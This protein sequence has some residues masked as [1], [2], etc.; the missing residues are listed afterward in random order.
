MVISVKCL[1]LWDPCLLQA[2]CV[3]FAWSNVIIEDYKN[4]EI[5]ESKS[6]GVQL[7]KECLLISP[8]SQRNRIR[9]TTQPLQGLLSFAVPWN[10]FFF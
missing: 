6:V 1:W 7:S 8:M 2:H 10:N 4:H 3:L 9:N 5:K